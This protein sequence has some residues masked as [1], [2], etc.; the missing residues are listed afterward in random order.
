MILYIVSSVILG[1]KIHCTGFSYY[2]YISP[3]LFWISYLV[4]ASCSLLWSFLILYSLYQAPFF[5]L[6]WFFCSVIFKTSQIS[7]SDLFIW[8]LL[9]K[10]SLNFCILIDQP[11]CKIWVWILSQF[12]PLFLFYS[13]VY[14]LQSPDTVDAFQ[15]WCRA[16]VLKRLERFTP[17]V[18][19]CRGGTR[20]A[21]RSP[22]FRTWSSWYKRVQQWGC[23]V[24]ASCNSSCTCHHQPFSKS[25]R[26]FQ[27]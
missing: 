1:V 2:L 20:A 25:T 16:V 11:K 26:L 8:C 4:P 18:S 5:H 7:H 23:G 3:Y 19:L 12:D 6:P 17:Q 9:W 24:P 21:M 14:R 15:L 27:V 10:R 13:S 22:H